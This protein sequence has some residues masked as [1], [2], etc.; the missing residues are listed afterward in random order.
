MEET[1]L[2]EE[3]QYEE[4]AKQMQE[5]R[6]KARNYVWN[7]MGFDGEFSEEEFVKKTQED[8]AEGKFFRF[9]DVNFRLNIEHLVQGYGNFGTEYL[10]RVM[11]QDKDSAIN[12]FESVTQQFLEL[13]RL[14][15]DMM[16][17]LQAR[18]TE[19]EQPNVEMEEN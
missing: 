18:S 14:V 5:I 2:T 3:Q 19:A 16:A 11:E 4:F 8:P 15:G 1:K 17:Q 7:I 6:T 10:K 13:D 12:M 9:D